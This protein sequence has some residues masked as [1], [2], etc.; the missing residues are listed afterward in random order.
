M[1]GVADS[2]AAGSQLHLRDCIERVFP[3]YCELDQ[4]LRIVAAGP[5]LCKLSAERLVGAQFADHF[6]GEH[7]STDLSSDSFRHMENELFIA[8]HQLSGVRLRGQVLNLGTPATGFMV[9]WSPWFTS[10]EAFD[11]LGLSL[12]DFGV[13]DPIVDM[14]YV[15]QALERAAIEA[16]VPSKRLERFFAISP[17]LLLIFDANGS[18]K[19]VNP[20]VTELLG[21]LPGQFMSVLLADQIHP[22]DRHLFTGA[23]ADLADGRVVLDLDLRFKDATDGWK[24]LRLS[25]LAAQDDQ[26]IYAAARDISASVESRELAMLILQSSPDGVMLLNGNGEITFANTTLGGMFGLAENQIVGQNIESIIPCSAEPEH[27]SSRVCIL[28]GPEQGPASGVPPNCDVLGKT[29]VGEDIPLQITMSRIRI[30]GQWQLLATV[31]DIRERKLL[32]KELLA[33]R[34]AA[35]SLAKAKTDFM[36]NTSHEIRTPL[37]AIVA[38]SELLADTEIDENQRGMVE[39]LN[40]A[41]ERLLRVINE[42]LTFSKLDANPGAIDE[43]LFSPVELLEEC[44]RIVAPSAEV[45]G[46][47]V[48]VQTQSG[49]LDLI[50]ADREKLRSI[51]LNIAGNAVKFTESGRVELRLIVPSTTS[52]TTDVLEFQIED[53]GLGLPSGDAQDLFRPFVQA[54]VSTTRKYGGTGLGLAIS[55]R[56]VEAMGG[57][58]SARNNEGPGACFTV[59]IPRTRSMVPRTTTIVTKGSDPSQSATVAEPLAGLNV[60]LV[61]DD[62]INAEIISRML[63]RLGAHPET[64]PDGAKALEWLA[65]NQPDVVLMDCQMPVMDGFEATRALRRKEAGGAHTPV[66]ALTASALDE[67][68]ERCLG[69]GMDAV[70]SKPIRMEELAAG[71][72][73]YVRR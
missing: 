73:D 44:A 41:C 13:Q 1:V 40:L 34:D 3:F 51:L 28:A 12:T 48:R 26:L 36:A 70:L 23:L 54:D 35:I 65:K 38:I 9:I 63:I 5:S 21:V 42:V 8:H 14:L 68:R 58:I 53:T 60:L 31:A 29:A 57:Q 61:E 49:I 32:E 18:V 43:S 71:L 46:I 2:G 37:T 66:V 17:D 52:V 72:A 27:V 19:L 20:A 22:E 10:T 15:L 47:E 4:S 59:K 62:E 33:A 64:A 69:A 50:L 11:N 39:T 67:D 55:K 25:A 6:A 16:A 56:Y 45:R 30:G 24:W 7:Y